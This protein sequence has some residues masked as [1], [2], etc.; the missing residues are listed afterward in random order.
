MRDRIR[1]AFADLPAIDVDAAHARLRA[2]GHE[3]CL[4]FVQ[5]TRTNAHALGQHHD[6]AAFGRFVGE[7]GQLCRVGEFGHLD[8]FCMP[9][10]SGLSVAERDRAGLVEQQH[11]DVARRFD[12][13]CRGRHHVRAQHAVHP[14]DA[15]RR[16][17]SADRGRD[18]AH[19]QCDEHAHLDDR[20]RTRCIDGEARERVQRHH[21]HQEHQRQRGQQDRQRDLVR[22]P[23][24]PGAFHHRDHSIEK[25]FAGIGAHP[26]H[27]PVGDHARAA[28]DRGAITTGAADHRSRFA[29]NRAL[30]DRGDAFD[31]IA[32][33]RNEMTCLDQDV[34]AESQCTGGDGRA[35]CV[36]PGAGKLYRR[37]LLLRVA[38]TRRLGC[39]ATF[40]ERFGEVG[41]QQRDPQPR[42]DR[43][44]EAVRRRGSQQGAQ[45]RTEPHHHQHRVVPQGC[46]PQ[47]QQR[48]DERQSDERRID[49]RDGM[50]AHGA[51]PINAR[52]SASGPSAS[53]GTKV[54]APTRIT[55]PISSVTNSGVCVG[56]VPADAAT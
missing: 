22:G 15:D 10:A 53:A 5:L 4:E 47:P 25:R 3:G 54:S 29:G 36:A 34:I 28:G 51:A 30:V 45:H 18:Q 16:E 42:C 38:Q 19:Q 20:P 26:Y 14:G 31:R 21:D 44:V 1:C 52:C 37:E 32:V 6:R 39:A 17:Q 49:A 40:G 27:Q 24:S 46:G 13:A 55:V 8:A 23:L 9:E 2:E 7:R 11:V 12:R 56:S 41:E 43:D 35:R 50:R 48:A 33:G